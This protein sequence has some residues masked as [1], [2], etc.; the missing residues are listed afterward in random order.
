MEDLSQS[1]GYDV[2]CCCIDVNQ[3]CSDTQVKVLSKSMQKVIM[4]AWSC[5]Q[6]KIRIKK[7][8]KPSTT[9]EFKYGLYLRLC[10][11]TK[12]IHN[13]KQ[14]NLSSVLCKGADCDGTF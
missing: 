9:D 14:M 11:I 7:I 8:L 4:P 10:K 1:V 13:C 6:N 12:R 3:L 2:F 5:C